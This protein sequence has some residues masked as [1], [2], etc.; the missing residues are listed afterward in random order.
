MSNNKAAWEEIHQQALSEFPNP[1]EDVRRIQKGRAWKNKKNG[2]IEP[3]TPETVAACK[4][5]LDGIKRDAEQRARLSANMER[6]A[7]DKRRRHAQVEGEQYAK[8][9][10]EVGIR[11][12]NH[13]ARKKDPNR[14]DTL[15]FIGMIAF[16]SLCVWL[17]PVLAG[18]R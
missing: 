5:V 11:H 2:M 10:E 17:M 6:H 3:S 18:A 14:F 4:A 12:A 8:H 1:L 16:I 9:K 13:L 15:A 7:Q